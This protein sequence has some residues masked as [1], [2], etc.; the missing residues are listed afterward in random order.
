MP[1]ELFELLQRLEEEGKLIYTMAALNQPTG[2]VDG[3]PTWP[4]VCSYSLQVHPEGS[5]MYEDMKDLPKAK[6]GQ[7]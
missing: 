3:Q 7:P 5:K 2:I 1:K 6:E 4:A